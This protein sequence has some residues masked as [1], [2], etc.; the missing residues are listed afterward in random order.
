MERVVRV[1]S[2]AEIL[3]IEDSSAADADP[4]QDSVAPSVT[5]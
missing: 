1:I 4:L 5:L 3:R 2:A